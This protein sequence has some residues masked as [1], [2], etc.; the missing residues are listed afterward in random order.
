MERYIAGW[1]RILPDYEFIKWDLKKFDKDTSIWVSEAVE[2]KKYAFAS[3]Y[4]RIYAVYHYGGIYL[5][6][7]VEVLKPFD[8]LLDQ[9][10]MFAYE[11]PDK[12]RIEAGCFGAEKNDP[13]LKTCLAYYKNRHFI[14]SE[15]GADMQPLSKVMGRIIRK[16]Y[17]EYKVYSHEYFTAKSYETGIETAGENT[18]AIH[19][20]AGSW[21]SKEERRIEKR[22]RG[23]RKAH[24]IAGGFAAFVYEKTYKSLLVIKNGGI[25][26]LYY[27]IR[28]Y[29]D[30]NKN[31]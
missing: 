1:K 8:E 11:S 19:H 22:A 10:Y 4:I 15:A 2:K 27:R 14:R 29:I 25:R 7:D 28:E 21:K 3:D 23:I 5:D 31:T 30:G 9:A 17:P 12:K 16:R 6:M 18:Y 26:E 13:F 24:P 20:F